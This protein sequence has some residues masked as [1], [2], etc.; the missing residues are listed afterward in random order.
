MVGI[1]ETDFGELRWFERLGLRLR[2]FWDVRRGRFSV[3]TFQNRMKQDEEK[4]AVTSPYAI[5]EV[6]RYSGKREQYLG[7]KRHLYWSIR[8]NL[9]RCLRWKRFHTM[10]RELDEK[11]GMLETDINIDIMRTDDQLD[12]LERQRDDC[13][14]RRELHMSQL[15]INRAD[16]IRGEFY[17]RNVGKYQC[18]KSLI[19]EKLSK[20]ETAQAHLQAVRRRVMVRLA[21]YYYRASNRDSSLN[22]A[23]MSEDHL[24][25]M[26]D[27]DIMGQYQEMIKA[28][29][30]KLENIDKEISV[31]SAWR[32]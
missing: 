13:D 19:Y 5:M 18:L 27:L 22:H 23:E 25:M 16:K 3:E 17:D 12:M 31:L 9:R 7:K 6:R 32:N 14:E 24:H 11:I 10:L 1:S 30:K 8:K 28:L 21:Y 20:L 15:Y 4:K 29:A 2:A 26:G